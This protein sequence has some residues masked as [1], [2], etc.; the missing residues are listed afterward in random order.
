MRG[1]RWLAPGSR[2]LDFAAGHGRHA[3]AAQALGLPVVAADRDRAAL[4]RFGSPALP[5]G[6]DASRSPADTADLIRCVVADLEADPWPFAPGSFDAVI[7]T[8]YLHRPRFAEL[9]QLLAPAGLLIYET[10]ARGNERYGRPSNPDFLLEPGELIDRCRAAG[11]FVL[12]FEDGV[13]A[14]GRTA[15]MQRVLAL[16]PE[17]NPEGFAIE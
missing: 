14:S 5:G 17:A 3:R 11:L 9:C 12:A 15:R 13:I 7:V 8:H 6:L 10:F 4:E 2:V 1:L 16:G